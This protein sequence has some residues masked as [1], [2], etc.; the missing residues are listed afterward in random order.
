[1]NSDEY[2]IKSWSA[3]KEYLKYKPDAIMGIRCRKS[4]QQSVRDLVEEKNLKLSFF[5]IMQGNSVDI[6]A[7]FEFAVK[8]KVCVEFEFLERVARRVDSGRDLILALDHLT[9]SRN[10]GA[11]ARSAGFF[12][13][14]DMVIPTRR[15]VTLN[16]ASVATAQGG[17]SL[18]S[19]TEVVNLS[20][21]LE[22]L[23]KYGYWVIGTDMDGEDV[24]LIR[25]AYSK[26][27]LVLGSEDKGIS[28]KVKKNC[29]RIIGI[30]GGKPGLESL[31]VSVAC[32]IF[33]NELAR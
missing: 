22:T 15:Q 24:A 14:S 28:A 12:G 13:V 23:K 10:L 2:L 30:K 18:V 33:L 11:I 17:F 20:R 19:L 32:G 1:M 21:T 3:F 31:N 4:L 8:L 25:G 27:V 26:T 7:S 5:E 29:D 16:S 6:S 9:D